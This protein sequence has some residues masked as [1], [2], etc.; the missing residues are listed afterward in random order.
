MKI[1]AIADE[2]CPAL[3]DYYVPGR[4]AD[5]DLIISCGDLNPKYL[6]FIVTM[7]RV[8]VLYVHGNHDASYLHRPPEGC[9][10]IDGKV[11]EYKGLRIAG[12]G[13]CK[14][15]MGAYQYSDGQMWKRAK[16]LESGIKKHKGIDIFVSH[17]APLDR[18]D[19]D[20]D[21]HRGFEAFCHINDTYEPKYHFF[22]HC[23]LS[24]SP[25][26]SKAVTV[27]GGTTMVN[28]SGDYVVSYIV[29]RFVSGKNWLQKQLHPERY[30][31]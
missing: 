11:I 31:K 10:D 1:L 12:L 6:S 24:G 26:N 28:A 22:G 3:Y 30:K 4:L 2:E 16:K 8:P 7:A 25:V 5:Y 9:V 15:Q 18:C 19:G 20:D 27:I 17:A 13:G 23:H 14:G 21:F 29:E